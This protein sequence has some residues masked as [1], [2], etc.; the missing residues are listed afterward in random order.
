MSF[1]RFDYVM[2]LIRCKFCFLFLLNIG[3]L[4]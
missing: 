1:R 3:L 2:L 4:Y